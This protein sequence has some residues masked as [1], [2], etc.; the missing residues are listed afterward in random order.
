MPVCAVAVPEH[1]CV[2][3]VV[4]EGLQGVA[5]LHQAVVAAATEAVLAELDLLCQ[6]H[7]A[8]ISH[9]CRLRDRAAANSACQQLR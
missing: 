4:H 8:A 7:N 9:S 1:L 3:A 5:A 2:R 6:V